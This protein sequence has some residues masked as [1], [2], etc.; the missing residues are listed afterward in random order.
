MDRRRFL[1]T[2]GALPLASAAL[3]TAPRRGAGQE[4]TLAIDGLGEIR[5]DYPPS[6]LDEIRAAGTRG[7]VVTVGNPGLYGEE[8]LA[9]TLGEIA[10]YE[11][12]IDA[13]PERLMRVRSVADLDEAAR[14]GRI[15]LVYY[16][17]NA[18]PL[19]RDPERLDTLW[20][21]G[22]RILQL[23][24]NHRNLLGDGSGERTDAGLSEFGLE[25]VARM[26]GLGML[27]DVSH[28]GRATTLDAIRHS[29]APIAITHAG[30]AAVFDHPR[31]KTDEA[32][33]EMAERGGVVGIVQL[34]P[35]L[36]PRE[37][38]T[39]ADYLA[40]IRHAVD[41]CGIDHVAVGSDRE[42]RTIPDTPEERQKLVDELARLYPD[43][44]QAPPVR[45]P[46][47]LS[48]L[49]HP[50]RMETVHEGLLGAG[51]RPREAEKILW[52]NWYRL[53]ADVWPE[54]QERGGGGD[55]S[56]GAARSGRRDSRAT[57]PDHPQTEIH[58][59]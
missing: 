33:R 4:P 36:G 13:H 20:D 46:F 31:N 8:A 22:V 10:A 26:N 40:H 55:T 2:A 54:R 58:P 50:R 21:A 24:Y 45:W 1:R 9:D 49:N 32:L 39:L 3:A 42:H 16:P 23:T 52:G 14:T 53:F 15:G 17:Q 5:L 19:A 27:V 25:V 18:T 30:C 29:T 12:H 47:F 56:E 51:F 35:Y 43:P 28:S 48:E 37:R 11:A 34:N 57:A 44:S 6:L 59:W 41:V 38:N 7:C